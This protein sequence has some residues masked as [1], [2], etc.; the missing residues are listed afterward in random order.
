MLVECRV[1]PGLGVTWQLSQNRTDLSHEGASQNRVPRSLWTL[2]FGVFGF[3]AVARISGT[4]FSLN[5]LAQPLRLAFVFRASW[6]LWLFR[7]GSVGTAHAGFT[8]HAGIKCFKHFRNR[9]C[10][11]VHFKCAKSCTFCKPMYFTD[12]CHKSLCRTFEKQPFPTLWVLTS[13]LL[14]YF[15]RFL[16]TSF[17]SESC[18]RLFPGQVDVFRPTAREKR[19]DSQTGPQADWGSF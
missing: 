4:R 14:F 10:C 2:A 17:G 5:G 7:L 3:S 16:L 19:D 15:S 1:Y 6:L 9:T 8:A 13:V 12:V 11:I 18:S